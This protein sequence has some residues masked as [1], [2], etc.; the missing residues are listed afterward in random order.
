MTNESKSSL[1]LE[2]KQNQEQD[3][4]HILLELKANVHKKCVFT[5]EEGGDGVL[6]Y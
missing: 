6:K 5:F 4:D 3:Q 2:V 1:V